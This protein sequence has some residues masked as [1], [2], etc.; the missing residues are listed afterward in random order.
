[1][2]G[3]FHKKLINNDEIDHRLACSRTKNCS[4]TSHF[5]SYHAA[6]RDHEIPTKFPI[7]KM[8]IDAGITP[9]GNSKCR[10]CKSNVEDVNHIT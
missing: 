9:S 6:I 5:E 7:H 3:N 8:Q 2:H 1:M 10:L 4:M